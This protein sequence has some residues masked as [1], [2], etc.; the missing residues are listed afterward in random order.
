MKS[1]DTFG[2]SCCSLARE[3]SWWLPA[4]WRWSCLFWWHCHCLSS[5]SSQC[6]ITMHKYRCWEIVC[7]KERC[8][9]SP[10]RPP[11]REPYQGEDLLPPSSISNLYSLWENSWCTEISGTQTCFITAYSPILHSCTSRKPVLL[12][13]LLMSIMEEPQ[14]VDCEWPLLPLHQDFPKDLIILTQNW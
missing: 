12:L 5:F 8:Q 9:S 10:R 11:G 1:S 7:P 3:S 2:R 13:P 6:R 4:L 14:A